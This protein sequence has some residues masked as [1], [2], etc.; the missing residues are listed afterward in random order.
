MTIGCENLKATGLFALFLGMSL[1][2]CGLSRWSI[3]LEVYLFAIPA[4]LNSVLFANSSI[5]EKGQKY[6]LN[7]YMSA[8][9]YACNIPCSCS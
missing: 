7:L 3:V 5:P 9:S 8:G 4:M 6:S 1:S 2:N